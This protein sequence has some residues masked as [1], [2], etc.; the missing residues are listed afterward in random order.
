MPRPPEESP[1]RRALKQTIM[2]LVLAG[3]IG[4]A[5]FVDAQSNKLGDPVRFDG[6]TLQLPRPS[7]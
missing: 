3:T 5:A 2:W 7:R 1:M 4:A 6:I